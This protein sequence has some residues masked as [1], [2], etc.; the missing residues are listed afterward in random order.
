[1]SNLDN[2]TSLCVHGHVVPTLFIIGCMKC[3]TTSLHH[4][5]LMSAAD[6]CSFDATDASEED[7]P[8]YNAKF[9]KPGRVL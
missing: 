6:S 2:S 4:A 5:L 3:A 7:I 1:M 9:S 8:P